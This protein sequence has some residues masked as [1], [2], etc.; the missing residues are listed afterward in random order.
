MSDKEIIA[1]IRKRGWEV[2]MDEDCTPNGT[3]Q[4]LYQAFFRGWQTTWKSSLAEVLKDVKAYQ[5]PEINT[6]QTIKK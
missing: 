1:E 5:E 4:K 6:E 3:D 2:R